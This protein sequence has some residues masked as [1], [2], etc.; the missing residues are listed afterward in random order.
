MAA[1]HEKLT[2]QLNVLDFVG[3]AS[4]SQSRTSTPTTSSYRDRVTYAMSREINALDTQNT[5]DILE[6]VHLRLGPMLGRTM[7]V[8]PGG[9]RDLQASFRALDARCSQNKMRDDVRAQRYHVRR[10]QAK[11]ELASKRWRALFKE[12]YFREVG[13]MRRMKGQGW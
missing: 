11:K 1:L 10:G 3:G 12:G 8:E 9:G 7:A 13:R 4:S 6:S 2:Q 5:K